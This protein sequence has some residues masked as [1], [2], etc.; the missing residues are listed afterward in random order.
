MPKTE[1]LKKLE[2][3][4]DEASAQRVWGAIEIEFRDGAPV[5]VRKMTTEKLQTAGE[6]NRG[7]E[8]T[9]IRW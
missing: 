2:T 7:Y 9:K 4:I 1:L 3:L 5:I 6:N 8:R